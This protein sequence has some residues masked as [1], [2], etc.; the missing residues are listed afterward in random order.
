MRSDDSKSSL[1]RPADFVFD[2]D[3]TISDPLLGIHRCMNF[4]LSSIGLDTVTDA[5]VAG[6]IGP[7]LDQA[8]RTLAP[9]CSASDIARLIAKYRE[10]YAQAGYA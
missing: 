6:L 2:L 3:G 1:N 4:A 9:E 7:P 8:F 5:T 10:R